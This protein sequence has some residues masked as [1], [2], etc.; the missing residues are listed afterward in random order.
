DAIR[1]LSV[2]SHGGTSADG[3]QP[4]FR[5]HDSPSLITWNRPATNESRWGG[6]STLLREAA[7]VALRA[8]VAGIGD[9]LQ[10][11]AGAEENRSGTEELQRLPIALDRAGGLHL[12]TVARPFDEVADVLGAGRLDLA[13]ARV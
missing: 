11:R 4:E 9:D 5:F 13:A 10:A 2:D 6:S 7:S 8:L 3:C 12:H 1:H